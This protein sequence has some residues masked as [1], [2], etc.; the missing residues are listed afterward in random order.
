MKIL[1]MGSLNYDYV[2]S[3]NHIVKPGE[4]I[5][6]K[7]MEI[8]CGGKGLNQSVALARAGEK[9]YHAG[10]IGMDGD[11]LL[12]TC[13]DNKIDISF[14]KTIEGK[15]GHTIIQVDDDGQNCILLYGGSNQSFTTDFI[16]GVLDSFDKGDWILLQNEVNHLNY[17]IDLAYDK[18]IKIALNPSPFNQS[19]KECD[20]TK[21]SLFLLNEI[22]GE[23]ITGKSDTKE[24][25]KVM[26]EQYKEAQI[27]L[28]LGSEGVIYKDKTTQCTH[29]V[30]K[31]NVVDTTAAGDT[32]TG[33]FICA[34]LHGRPIMEVLELSSKASAIAVSR[35]GATTSIPYWNEV[36]NAEL[37]LRN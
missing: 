3:V 6:S 9:V 17:I 18:G 32:F 37:E 4:T 25:L 12:K 36:E 20:L 29:G 35:A 5:L 7:K 27:V 13:S 23:Q 31:V 8:F 26:A 33:Y 24:I 30:Y 19:I 28:T 2:Y 15:S 10:M 34:M 21:V 14:I 11:F 16:D 22:E 1:N